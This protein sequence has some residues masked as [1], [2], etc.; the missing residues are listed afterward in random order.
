MSHCHLQPPVQGREAKTPALSEF[1][2]SRIGAPLK[3]SFAADG[4]PYAA[5]GEAQ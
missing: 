1:K 5:M 2:I 4:I 3:D